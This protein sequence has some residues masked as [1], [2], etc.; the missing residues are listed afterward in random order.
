MGLSFTITGAATN[1]LN[2]FSEGCTDTDSQATFAPLPIEALFGSTKS[3]E[4]IKGIGTIHPIK[5]GLKSIALTRFVFNEVSHFEDTAIG[6]FDH[7][8]IMLC[9]FTYDGTDARNDVG[10]LVVFASIGGT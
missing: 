1:N 10:H 9:I 7:F 6:R 2:H 4:N 8:D 5:V 3:N